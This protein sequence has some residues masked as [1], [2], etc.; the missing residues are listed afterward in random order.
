MDHSDLR[1]SRGLSSLLF[2]ILSGGRGTIGDLIACDSKTNWL[3]L[4][5]LI[6]DKLPQSVVPVGVG[7]I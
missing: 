5:G 3:S 1:N 6:G 4:I 7:S 2:E